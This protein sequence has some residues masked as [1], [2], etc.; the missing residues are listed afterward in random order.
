[1]RL[2]LTACLL[3]GC[4]WAASPELEQAAR[5]YRQTQYQ[6]ALDTLKSVR[7]PDA[8]TLLLTGQALYGLRKYTEATDAL[9]RAAKL[10][11]RSADIQH[12]LGRAWG[13]RA[14]TSAVWNQLRYAGRA[15]EAFERA[16][17]IDPNHR[18][19]LEDLFEYYLEAPGIAGGGTDKAARLV[20]RMTAIDP[21]WGARAQARID[22][23]RND[24]TSA[25]RQL[26]RAVELAPDKPEPVVDLARFLARRG[27]HQESDAAFARAAALAPSDPAVWF[28]RAKALV[29][30]NRQPEQ[31]RQLLE[32]Y[33]AANLTPEHP[34]REEARELLARLERRRN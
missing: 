8:E 21:A 24:F 7:P 28:G 13:R 11:P 9:E 17:E 16:L 1:M 32:R 15:R 19:A 31:A 18:G 30:A 2:A 25:E 3:G 26:R 33:L 22:E 5:L 23:R 20:P 10:A 29:E 14:E 34:P 12:W 27:R 4:A 6:Q